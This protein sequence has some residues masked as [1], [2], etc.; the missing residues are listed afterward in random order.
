MVPVNLT[1]K[2]IHF[3]PLK[4]YLA[5]VVFMVEALSEN[6]FRLCY[7]NHAFLQT[8]HLPGNEAEG[9]E[10]DDFFLPDVAELLKDQLIEC[11]SQRKEIS[12]K[13]KGWIFTRKDYLCTRLFPIP[14]ENQQIKH[15][16]CIFK[17]ITASYKKYI[18]DP[19][20][21]N[22]L[23]DIF[24]T[25]TP[26]ANDQGASADRNHPALPIIPVY[27]KLPGLDMETIYQDVTRQNKRLAKIHA[28]K[29]ILQAILNSLSNAV[30]F[31]DTSARLL[32]FNKAAEKHMERYYG[33]PPVTGSYIQELAK[34]D[35]R[36]RLLLQHLQEVQQNKEVVFEHFLVYPDGERAW[37]YRQYYPAFD[38]HG[39][40]MGC[41]I[42]SSNITAH[43]KRELYISKQ[44]EQLIKIAKIQK[45]EL[46]T[47][48]ATVLGIIKLLTAKSSL[49]PELLS[50]L[51]KSAG[52]LE[53]VIRN[54]TGIAETD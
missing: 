37:F 36:R 10:I 19:V 34:N 1:E 21:L 43:K 26:I 50:L 24:P 30:L 28:S 7:A 44:N 27:P 14:G 54:K 32:H 18:S 31:I 49:D 5:E 12:F 42:N 40:Y 38:S 17:D 6:N 23:F 47:P 29:N 8:V 51:K 53:N 11:V 13:H 48:L 33:N 2:Q 41:V 39:R 9:A 25:F 46:T 16:L 15:I 4:K 35:E 20:L 52:E 22:R 45:E 3:N